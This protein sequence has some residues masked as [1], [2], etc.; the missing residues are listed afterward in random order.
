MI[1]DAVHAART[2][3][4]DHLW[5]DRRCIV[6]DSLEDWAH[7]A[8]IMCAVYS[9]ATFTLSTNG[10]NSDNQ[11]LFRSNQNLSALDYKTYYDPGGDNMVYIKRL[12]HAPLRLVA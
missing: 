4:L 5:I 7:E 8:A 3:G 1:G 11:D 6:Q 12:S 2:L 9:G 10:S